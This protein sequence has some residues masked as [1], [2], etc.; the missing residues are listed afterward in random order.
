MGMEKKIFYIAEQQRNK[1]M[2]R[3]EKLFEPNI[4]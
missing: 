2:K 3:T 1:T 4:Q